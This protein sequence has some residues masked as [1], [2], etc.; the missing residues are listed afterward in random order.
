M[1]EQVRDK[2]RLLHIV[3]AIETILLRV[4]GM[5]L[6][7]LK[8]DKI[9]FGGIVYYTMII[10][11]AT[12]KLTRAFVTKHPN[13]PWQSITDMRHHIVHGYYQVD[14][15]ILWSIIQN[16]MRPLKAQIEKILS[17]TNWDEWEQTKSGGEE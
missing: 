14:A 11:E 3:D 4:E 5:T 2:E 16:D 7:S 6:E 1:R 8:S 13:V 12:Y 9:V 17:E 10:G 15:L